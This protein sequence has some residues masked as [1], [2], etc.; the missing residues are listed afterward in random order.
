[1]VIATHQ[2]KNRYIFVDQTKPLATI[3]CGIQVADAPSLAEAG[4]DQV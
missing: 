1:M 4:E 3:G 2:G